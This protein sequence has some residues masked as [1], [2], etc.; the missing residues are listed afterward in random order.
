M[1]R[2]VLA[3]LGC[4]PAGTGHLLV[5]H[6]LSPIEGP[7]PNSIRSPVKGYDIDL[8]RKSTSEWLKC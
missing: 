5:L 2:F 1:E 6:N 4:Y 7:F 8:V 3:S